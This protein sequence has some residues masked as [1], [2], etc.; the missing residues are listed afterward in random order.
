MK[1]AN[2]VEVLELTMNLGQP[3]MIHPTLVWD[4]NE[5]VLVDTGI[6]GQLKE[7]QEA[8]VQAGVAFERLSK[9]ILTHQDF[10]HI[11]SL[12]AILKVTDY[13]IEVL[14]H[15]EDQPY[16]QGEKPF[17]KMSPERIKTLLETL[18][19]ER[20]KYF[21]DPITAKVDRTLN[22][23]EVL[24]Y[25]GGITVIFT[26]GHT[27]GHMS[28]YLKESKVL[29]AGDA[30]VADGGKLLG[31]REQVTPDMETARKSL[32]KLTH[33]DIETVICY[34]GGVVTEQVNEQIK[35]LIK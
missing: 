18:P 7:I 16:I 14:A 26:P 31:P 29:I 23:G 12:N 17:L 25:C 4:E 8:M 32:E 11:G 27:P 15:K 1:I 28:L 9:V 34:H 30:M 33:Y 5:V 35:A 13:S 2:D 10:D 20:A 6:P 24:P 3:S 19:K 22:D 21:L